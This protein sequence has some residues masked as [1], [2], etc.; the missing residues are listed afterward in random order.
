[1]NLMTDEHH[2]GTQGGRVEV[3]DGPELPADRRALDVLDEA[4][5]DV[6]LAAPQSSFRTST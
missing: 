5:R 1:M 3:V 4:L 2:S 6:D